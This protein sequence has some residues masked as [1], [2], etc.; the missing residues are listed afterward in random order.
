MH[1]DQPDDIVHDVFLETLWGTHPL[2]RRVLGTTETI[3]AMTRDQ[4]DAYYRLHYRPG[5]LVVA[6]AG[7]LEHGE[8]VDTVEKAFRAAPASPQRHGRSGDQA[9]AL[10]PGYAAVSRPTEQAHIVYGTGAMS[11]SDP[12][13][14]AFGVLNV[15][16]GAGMSSRLFQEVREKR[17]WVY[18][19]YSMHSSFADSGTFEIYAGTAPSRARDVLSLVRDEIASVVESGIT[20][21]EIERGKGH[22]KGSLVLGLEDTGGRMSR[23]GKGELVHGEILTPD[24]IVERIDAV[25]AEDIHALAREFL[26]GQP[27][28]LAVIAPPEVSGLDDY[29]TSAPRA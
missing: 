11:R 26:G 28:A 6:A 17:G 18:S 15:V 14:W 3:T 29:V 12:R 4:I 20:E 22:L 13:R 25:T 24:E 1:E 19:I 23:L 8:V 9:P 2:G 16:I 10:R 5:N 21:E 7:S 27:W